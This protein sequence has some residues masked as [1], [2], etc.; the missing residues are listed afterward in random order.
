MRKKTIWQLA[1]LILA[2]WFVFPNTAAAAG[3]DTN[4]LKHFEWMIGGEWSNGSTVQEFEWGLN[5]KSVKA[6]SYTVNEKKRTLVSE[7]VWFWHPG[8]KVIKG[9]FSAV[10]MPFSFVDSEA[11]F[12]GQRLIHKLETYSDGE[13]PQ[14][15]VEVME[16]VSEGVF[17]WKL[18][19]GLKPAGEELMSGRFKR[20]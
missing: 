20:K 12:D 13:K 10:G 15:Y 7:G 16:P 17:S 1:A 18:F 5:Q 9:Y 11:E 8:K 19:A 4:P 14:I 6:K 3:E 2:C